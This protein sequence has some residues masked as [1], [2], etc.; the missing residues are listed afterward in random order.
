MPPGVETPAKGRGRQQ[1][2]TETRWQQALQ[3]DAL[4]KEARYEAVTLRLANGVRYTPDFFVQ[5]ADGA[6]GFDEV[7][8]AFVRDAAR[9]K[10]EWARQQYPSFRWRWCQWARGRWNVSEMAG[11]AR[12]AR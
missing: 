2:K 6:H 10:Y 4:V 7:K 12:L 5:Y 9:L 1:N 11:S 3:A 8:N